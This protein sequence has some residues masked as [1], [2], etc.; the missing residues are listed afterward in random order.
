MVNWLD[1]TTRVLRAHFSEDPTVQNRSDAIVDRLT[2]I[3]FERLPSRI[4]VQLL[5]LLPIEARNEHPT[6]GASAESEG[7]RSI[8]FPDFMDEAERTLGIGPLAPSLN[9]EPGAR[10]LPREIADIYLWAI[11]QD[12]P[13]E[14]K[15]RM[16]ETLPMELKSRMDL[17]SSQVAQARVA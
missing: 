7:D 10:N 6:L 3:L 16:T 12:V 1:S 15:I 2:A 8:G 4:S 13:A 11:V 9:D 5:E 17:Y 14:I